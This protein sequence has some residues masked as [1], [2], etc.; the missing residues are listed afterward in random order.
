MA[1]DAGGKA[2]V[3][4]AAGEPSAP[5][6]GRSPQAAR[7]P[8]RFAFIRRRP[9]ESL[10]VA[11]MVVVVPK[12][13]VVPVIAAVVPVAVMIAVVSVAVGLGE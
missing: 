8:P 13:A 1:I 3:R 12:I 2:L 10:P 9:G 5:P 7:R 6:A 4:D 11:M